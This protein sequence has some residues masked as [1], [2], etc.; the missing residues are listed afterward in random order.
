MSEVPALTQHA[1]PPGLHRGPESRVWPQLHGN[2]CPLPKGCSL[3]CSTCPSTTHELTNALK[4][5][6]PVTRHRQ[7]LL[8]CANPEDYRMAAR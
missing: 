1:T 4:V 3:Q 7:P 2:V 6:L 8:S 5:E